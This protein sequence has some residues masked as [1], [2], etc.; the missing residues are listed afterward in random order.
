MFGAS[1]RAV[2]ELQSSKMKCPRQNA[3]VSEAISQKRL[4]LGLCHCQHRLQSPRKPLGQVLAKSKMAGCKIGVSLVNLSWN[5]PASCAVLPA[6][7]RVF[8]GDMCV[9]SDFGLCV[10]VRESCSPRPWRCESFF[11]LQTL[12]FSVVFSFIVPSC[13]SAA[14]CPSS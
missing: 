10:R 8:S 13:H 3:K 9:A 14:A 1:Y 6:D 2:R 5:A 12:L 4:N 11:A 7:C